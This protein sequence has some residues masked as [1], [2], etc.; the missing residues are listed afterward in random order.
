MTTFAPLFVP[1]ELRAAVSGRAWLQG[2]LDAEQALATAGGL[3]GVVPAEAVAVIAA[4]C[5]ADAYD[6]ERLLREGRQVGAPAE[7]LVRA[8]VARVGEETARWV[9]LG[10]TTQDIMDTAAMLVAR[11]ALG[12]V[13]GELDRVEAA[14]AALARTYRET[15]MAGRTLMQQAVPITFG[16][17]AAGWLVAVLDARARL[18]QVRDHGL[19]AQLGG[20]AGTL[21]ALGDQGPEISR[22][23]A[24]ELGLAEA[25]V[26]W[27]TNRV[28][29]AELGAALD[30]A[31]GVLAKIAFDIVLLA[32]TEVGEVR[33][34]G[35]EGGSSAMPQKQNP[36]GA[37]RTRAAAALARAHASVLTG[38]L[39]QE[40]ERAAGSWQAEWE[41]LCGVLQYTGGA[42]ACLAGSLD[43]LEVDEERL[44]ANL[45]LTSGQIASERIASL[46]TE[47]LGR[48]AGRALVRDAS[49]RSSASG[50]SLA[51]E[52]ADAETGL[53]R[54][55][56]DDALEAGTYLGSS[57][58]LVDR[59]LARF[60]A[61]RAQ[62][63]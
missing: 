5:E 44:R 23:F 19:A 6:W 2:M 29:I 16:L 33:E 7:P 57:A 30:T 55:E 45:D 18:A 56:I 12:L 53:T 43:A 1:D 34:R 50:R 13:L 28:R 40:H 4:A 42:A 36:V 22:L 31:A 20:A 41:A 32:Q 3:A 61:L 15:P 63:Q 24:V 21:A 17:K 9:H 49:L 14:C 37:V 48:S 58:A 27:H 47:R 25:T 62:G 59:A 60:D 10:A 26:P 38:S 46:L 11:E 52:L 39:V 51:D 54:G 35:G 8:L